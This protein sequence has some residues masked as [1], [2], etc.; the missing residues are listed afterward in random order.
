MNTTPRLLRVQT[1][2]DMTGLPRSTLYMYMAEGRFPRPVKIG[3][4]SVAWA[5]DVIEQWIADRLTLAA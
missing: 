4:R 5:S 3:A 2:T 1:V